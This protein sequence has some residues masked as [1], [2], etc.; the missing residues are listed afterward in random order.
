MKEIEPAGNAH[1]RCD[2]GYEPEAIKALATQWANRVLPPDMAK[3]VTTSMKLSWQFPCPMTGRMRMVPDHPSPMIRGMYGQAFVLIW[4]GLMKEFKDAGVDEEDAEGR[5][6][7]SWNQFL[8]FAEFIEYHIGT[9]SQNG[10]NDTWGDLIGTKL[11]IEAGEL[12]E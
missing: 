6:K 1:Y 5:C 12:E 11:R 7:R 8:V 4:A 10:R 2:M 9:F 3:H